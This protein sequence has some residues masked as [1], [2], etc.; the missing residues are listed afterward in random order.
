MDLIMFS[1]YGDDFLSAS[2]RPVL[3]AGS[4]RFALAVN[5]LCLVGNSDWG[6]GRAFAHDGTLPRFR[7]WSWGC[8]VCHDADASGGG[9]SLAGRPV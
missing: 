4:P 8:P 5:R 6:D 1:P 7:L 2:G 3:H 9:R